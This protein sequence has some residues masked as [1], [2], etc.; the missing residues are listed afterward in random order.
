MKPFNK[1]QKE[2]IML[3]E[4]EHQKNALDTM[5]AKRRLKLGRDLAKAIY[6]FVS[7]EVVLLLGMW[8]WTPQY[9]QF[10][11][12][13]VLI[14]PNATIAMLQPVFEARGRS[15]LWATLFSMHVTFVILVIPILMPEAL[16]GAV[17]AYAIIFL[18]VGLL[19][20]TRLLLVGASLSVL[21]F[22]ANVLVG[23]DFA[24]IWFPP[25]NQTISSIVG[26]ALGVF[27]IITTG[28][29]FYLILNG[30][31]K[32][33]RQAQR[34]NMESEE[35][36]AI[37]EEANRAK[38]VFLANMSHELRTPL[39]AILGFSQLMARDV[40]LGA[41]HPE[42][43]EIINRSGEHLLGLINNVL[44][45]A[46]IESGHTTLQERR[47]DLYKLIESIAAMFRLRTNSKGLSLTVEYEP[48]MPTYIQMDDGKLR[49]VLINLLGN[50]VK[51]TNAGGITLRV[52]RAE[53]VDQLHF[54]VE[55][56]GPGIA[57]EELATLFEPF[58]QTASGRQTGEGTGLG[59]PISRQFVRLMGG[60]LTI[61]SQPGKGSLFSFD[62]P[63]HN[64]DA[65][66]I[67]QLTKTK[68]RV[69]GLEAGQQVYRLLIAE[70]QADSRQ[71]L[72]ELLSSVG[73][74]VKT[75][76]NGQEAIS[77]WQAWQPH[78]IWMD[79]RMSIMNG[80]EATKKIKALPAGQETVI[81]ALTASSF[82]EEREQILADGCDD[83]IRKPYR[84]EEIFDA[85]A[86]HLGVCF[87]YENEAVSQA[88]TAPLDL[89]G[90][91]VAWL[92][93]LEKAALEADA[94]EIQ[95]LAQQVSQ[96]QPVAAQEIIHLGNHFAYEVIIAAIGQA[97]EST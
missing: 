48:N 25:L 35:A 38:S 27:T 51:F 71:L 85:L 6:P 88:Q 47:F 24:N 89:S 44:D 15:N 77:I 42:H 87:I 28:V 66:E 26:L 64:P 63:A 34:A 78:L 37:A 68:P 23:H 59:L 84:E 93:Q 31:E 74:Q 21:G 7:V 73:F 75:A 54:E 60:E 70:D 65:S 3:I 16:L 9:I 12:F 57:P 39:N 91:P 19:S 61:S 86:R 79:M 80:R 46:K 30:Q 81:I 55:D 17:A 56:S 10:F 36:K 96:T 76:G 5:E 22:I 53:A 18:M 43:V 95:E 49:Q 50:A 72:V 1:K 2:T 20:G 13:A 41:V 92:S 83:F 32:L 58:S 69:I 11:W 45:M 94:E 4:S 52:S 67:S 90:L 14:A 62:L 82:V 33:Y 29:I 97:R 40:A 8:L